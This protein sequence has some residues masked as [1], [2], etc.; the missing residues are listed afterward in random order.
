[1]RWEQRLQLGPFSGRLLAVSPTAAGIARCP[2]RANEKPVRDSTTALAIRAA[3]LHLFCV[4]ARLISFTPRRLNIVTRN[5]F[6]N[7]PVTLLVSTGLVVMMLVH[8]TEGVAHGKAPSETH[9][10]PGVPLTVVAST[11]T[12]SHMDYVQYNAVCDAV[13]AASVP[14]ESELRLG[15]LTIILL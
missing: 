11:G 8:A 15:G 9:L 13:H 6:M 12:N 1:M 5:P 4:P 2:R 10:I 14:H 7:K 3:P